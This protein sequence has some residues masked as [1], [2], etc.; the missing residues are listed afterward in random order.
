MEA[1]HQA[2]VLMQVG[3][4]FVA[5][6]NQEKERARHGFKH[7]LLKRQKPD[8]TLV[9][10]STFLRLEFQDGKRRAVSQSY[11]GSGRT[12]SHQLTFV[13]R[14]D[15]AADLEALQLDRCVS[16]PL[17]QS[18]ETLRAYVV[19]SQTDQKAQTPFAVEPGAS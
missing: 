10:I 5:G 13:G 6:H 3:R 14:E 17:Q 15:R 7:Q 2:H 16:A 8:E 12:H 1:L 18:T 11:H 9:P 19:A 4:N